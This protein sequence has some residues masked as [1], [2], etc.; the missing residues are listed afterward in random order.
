VE[1]ADLF[2]NYG[3]RYGFIGRNGCGKSTFMRVIGSRCFPIPEGFLIQH[4]MVEIFQVPL[5]ILLGIDIFHLKEE[6]EPSEMTAKEAVMSVDV[7]RGFLEKEAEEI[8]DILYNEDGGES[9]NEDSAELMD[10]LTQIYERLEELDASTAEARASKILCGINFP[11]YTFSNVAL[12]VYLRSRIYARET[13][14][15]NQRI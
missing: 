3:N 2:L 12:F 1:E 11:V 9:G 7:E 8:N 13:E 5:I 10:R 14:Q 15:E 6:I 4:L